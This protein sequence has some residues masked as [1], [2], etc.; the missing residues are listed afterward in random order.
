MLAMDGQAAG[1]LAAYKPGTASTAAS[2]AALKAAGIRVIKATGDRLTTD[3]PV[4]ARWG[5]DEGHA[6]V[7]PADKLALVD[8]LQREV[9]IVAPGNRTAGPGSDHAHAAHCKDRGDRRR[10]GHALKQLCSLTHGRV[11]RS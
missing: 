4:E 6:D 8:K 11:V 2:R 7:K 10:R 9:R 5:I 3:R 1:L